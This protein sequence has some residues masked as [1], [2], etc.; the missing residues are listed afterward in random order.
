MTR[1][2]KIRN[3]HIR[4]TT[5]AV[6]ASKKITESRLKEEQIVRRM[7]DVDIPGKRK[8]GRPNLRWKVQRFI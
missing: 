8:R 2:E 7:L 5:R 4:G 1:R 6:Q 3:E